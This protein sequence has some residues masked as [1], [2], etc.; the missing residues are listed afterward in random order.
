MKELLGSPL[1]MA[2]E[3]ILKKPYNEKIDIWSIGIIIYILLSG[4]PPFFGHTKEEIF[5]IIL[6]KELDFDSAP[7]WGGVSDEAKN[8]VRL[9]L[10]KNPDKRPSCQ[11]LLNNTWLK[12]LIDPLK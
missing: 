10:C 5:K 9:A 2:P 12:N 8:F 3:I 11:H 4:R 6:E 7:E 1:Y